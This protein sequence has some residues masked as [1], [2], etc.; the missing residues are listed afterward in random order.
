MQILNHR[1]TSLLGMILEYLRP[2]LSQWAKTSGE[3]KRVLNGCLEWM[4]D[5]LISPVV[6]FLDDMKQEDKLII[7][8]PT[9]RSSL[10][11]TAK[12]M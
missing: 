6:N 1:Y 2:V 8:A 10:Y 9:V 7:V 4:Y 12:V 11:T 3:K 5:M